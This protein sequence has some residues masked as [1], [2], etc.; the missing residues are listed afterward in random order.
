AD[1]AQSEERE[2]QPTPQRLIDDG[3]R[4]KDKRHKQ[5][6][7]AD[8]D[9]EQRIEP[10]RFRSRCRTPPE[11]ET[12]ER[13]PTH[14]CGE[15]GADSK[16]S[17]AEDEDEFT[18]PDDLIDKTAETRSEEAKQDDSR[19]ASLF[20]ITSASQQCHQFQLLE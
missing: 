13:Q 3:E 9:F 6:V 8:A 18:Y 2:L 12:A 10:E 17:R 14:K 15:Y 1:N 19:R 20:V 4:S 7:D 16:S 11:I 5:T